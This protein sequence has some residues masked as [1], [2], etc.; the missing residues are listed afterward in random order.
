VPTIDEVA[1]AMQQAVLT[2]LNA[3]ELEFPQL[4]VGI[5]WPVGTS[6]SE[7]LGQAQAQVTVYP[8]E[9]ASQD[10]TNRRPIW[11]ESTDDPVL[12]TATVVGGIM[13]F[14]RWTNDDPVG[15][16]PS[17]PPPSIVLTFCGPVTAGLNIH[18]LVGQPPADAYYR[19]QST[20]EAPSVAT[21]VAAAINA[22]SNSLASATV[23]GNS[24]LISGV[25][26]VQCNIGGHGTAVK[27]SRRTMTPIQVSVWA[28]DGPNR[29]I[30]GKIIE[31]SDIGTSDHPFL[32]GCDGGAIRTRLRGSPKWR[33]K[34]QSSYSLY[35]WHAVYECEYPTLQVTRTTSIE[36]IPVTLNTNGAIVTSYPAPCGVIVGPPCGGSSGGSTTNTGT[37]STEPQSITPAEFLAANPQ[38]L[39]VTIYNNADATLYL[40]I[41]NT[42]SDEEFVW[43]VAPGKNWTLRIPYVGEI[44]GVWSASGPGQAN[45]GAFPS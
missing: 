2:A 45:I 20:D 24:V 10:R 3:S 30:L 22:L 14:W 13:P 9:A 40:G 41:D 39:G 37:P 12:L 35:E 33:D 36:A 38:R 29:N 26:N 7:I 42:L 23:S 34:S 44:W 15:G 8:I 6:A 11:K 27:E 17:D 5:G 19:T 18:T 1:E 21:A 4:Q 43:Q 25:S 31:L 28:A 32:I 16:W